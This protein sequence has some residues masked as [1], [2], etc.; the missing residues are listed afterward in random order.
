[1]QSFGAAS[2]RFMRH[3]QE[4]GTE[5]NA[6]LALRDLNSPFRLRIICFL[7]VELVTTAV[8]ALLLTP[9]S[10]WVCHALKGGHGNEH[11]GASAVASACLFAVEFSS[12]GTK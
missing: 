9:M 1:M 3:H 12:G 11:A 7:V 8:Y 6:S 4:P 10:C 5:L 2:V